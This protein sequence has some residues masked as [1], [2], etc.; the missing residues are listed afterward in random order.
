MG[1]AA[2]SL[3]S[4]TSVSSRAGGAPEAEAEAEVEVVSV[5]DGEESRDGEKHTTPG[6]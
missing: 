4:M 6:A 2:S 3:K 5:W 1:V